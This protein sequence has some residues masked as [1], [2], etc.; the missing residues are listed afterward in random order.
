MWQVYEGKVIVLNR[1]GLTSGWKQGMKSVVTTN[2]EKSAEAIVPRRL[3]TPREGLN[4]RRRQS[5]NVTGHG[6]EGRKLHNEGWA[7]KAAVEQ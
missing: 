6:D 7:Q 4:L 5:M 1:G 2:C 3:Q